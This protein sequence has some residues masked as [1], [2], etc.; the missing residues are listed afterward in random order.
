MSTIISVRSTGVANIA[1]APAPAS[2]VVTTATDTVSV[3]SSSGAV[4][5]QGEPTETVVGTEPET[6]ILQIATTSV[7]VISVN[8]GG[9]VGTGKADIINRVVDTVREVDPFEVMINY[10]MRM[11]PGGEIILNGTDGDTGGTLFLL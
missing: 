5:V 3:R 8:T 9:S 4:V 1:T 11:D 6:L 7:S 10:D 2:S